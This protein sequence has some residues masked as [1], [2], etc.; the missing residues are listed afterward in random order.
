MAPACT[1]LPVTETLG[2]L[3]ACVRTERR[4]VTTGTAVPPILMP[5]LFAATTD[6]SVTFGVASVC[7]SCETTSYSED[8]SAVSPHES[9]TAGSS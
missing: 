9:T 6:P 2:E 3:P 5:E 7:T 4:P 8:G 1:A